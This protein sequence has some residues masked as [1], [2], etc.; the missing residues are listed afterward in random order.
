MGRALRG[1]VTGLGC[2]TVIGIGVVFVVLIVVVVALSSGGGAGSG[3][4]GEEVKPQNQKGV[5][6]GKPVEVGEVQWVVENAKQATTLTSSY[7]KPAEGNFVVVNFGFT[8]NGTEAA[9]LDTTS[10]ALYDSK[11]RKS[12]VDTDKTSY[13]PSNLD[14]FLEN[15][16]PGV[17]KKGQVIFSVAPDA[18]G[19]KLQVGDT[20]M[21][22]DKNGYVDLGF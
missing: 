22:S 6:I 5:A 19:L 2:L 11:G 4:G 7:D 13:I 18:S 14:I 8:N 21:M 17:A 9:T 16:N 15:V 10:I 1:V 3:D 20:E 12:E